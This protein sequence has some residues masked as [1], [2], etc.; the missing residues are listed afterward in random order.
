[1][2][3]E[4]IAKVEE[5]EEP[6]EEEAIAKVEE[7]EEKPPKKAL[8]KVEELRAQAKRIRLEA[9][10]M[11]VILTLEKIS[12]IEKELASPKV[13]EDTER[14]EVLQGQMKELKKKL[15]GDDDAAAESGGDGGGNVVSAMDE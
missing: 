15:G 9:E 7:K 5:K 3:E 4:A 1:M 12:K 10:R 2:G 8:T 13:M 11:D 14:R 6:V